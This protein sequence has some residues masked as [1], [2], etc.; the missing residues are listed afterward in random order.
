MITEIAKKYE[1][2]K[3]CK[4]IIVD[5]DEILLFYPDYFKTKTELEQ[6]KFISKE[7][8]NQYFENNYKLSKLY[9]KLTLLAMSEDEIYNFIKHNMELKYSNFSLLFQ[10]L[11]TSVIKLCQLIDYIGHYPTTWPVPK[12]EEKNPELEKLLEEYDII[13]RYHLNDEIDKM[14]ITSDDIVRIIET[15]KYRLSYVNLVSKK[16]SNNEWLLTRN[17]SEEKFIEYVNQAI[18]EIN[19][20]PLSSYQIANKSKREEGKMYLRRQHGKDII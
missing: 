11:I 7:E 8:A 2:Y 5:Y 4:N 1:D 14:Q 9:A 18:I 19:D 3:K 20:F 16:I 12:T 10:E 13:V 15:L 17:I 6:L